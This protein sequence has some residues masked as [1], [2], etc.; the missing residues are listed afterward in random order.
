MRRLNGRN[1]FVM[2]A[3]NVIS[4]ISGQKFKSTEMRKT[5]DGLLVHKSEWYPKHPQLE[6]RGRDEK[7]GVSP[8][9][10]RQPTKFFVPTADDL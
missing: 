7:I 2:G 4:D 3:H 8:T 5:W 1:R 10:P 6:I 9:R